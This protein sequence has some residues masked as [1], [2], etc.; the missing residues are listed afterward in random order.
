MPATESL[1]LPPDDRMGV[2]YG[3]GS[4]VPHCSDRVRNATGSSDDC[5]DVHDVGRLSGGLLSFP[6]IMSLVGTKLTCRGGVKDV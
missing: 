6:H 5:C 2:A 4:Q 1:V 3:L